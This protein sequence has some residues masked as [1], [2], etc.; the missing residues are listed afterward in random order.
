MPTGDNPE[1]TSGDPNR[2]QRRARDRERKKEWRKNPEYVAAERTNYQAY[3]QNKRKD[4]DFL[5]KHRQQHADY[6]QE[7]MKNPLAR[8]KKQGT[9]RKRYWRKK[10]EREQREQLEQG[11]AA[12]VYEQY[13]EWL[14]WPQVPPTGLRVAVDAETAG[15]G[16]GV[17]MVQLNERQPVAGPSGM[18]VPP[19]VV[20]PFL[21]L[22]DEQ[23]WSQ[24]SAA[25]VDDH[26]Y[27]A[28]RGVHEELWSRLGVEEL[29]TDAVP[30]PQYAYAGPAHQYPEMFGAAG[31]SDMNEMAKIAESMPLGAGVS[32]WAGE[33]PV[34]GLPEATNPVAP[35]TSEH[36][37]DV[38]G[39]TLAGEHAGL[40]HALE[41]LS[42]TAARHH[43]PGA[44][45]YGL[46]EHQ[47]NV[48]YTQWDT[49]AIQQ[50]NTQHSQPTSA[51]P[52]GHGAGQQ[53]R[54]GH[55]A[56]R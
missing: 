18:S 4:P 48:A 30:Q 15:L 37:P 14:G 29:G 23:V 9:D 17:V 52:P 49:T 55:S 45:S 13:R 51:Y 3:M 39:P 8:A 10:Q 31:P 24:I 7:W 25:G 56:H 40:S 2:D 43:F 36:L 42:V 46:V 32:A 50:P 41:G 5:E 21:D 12:G 22:A 38:A 47:P 20:D 19:V 11:V 16:G 53:A 27:G 33:T 44:G 6:M 28:A 26:D 1:G 35:F 34:P 54:P